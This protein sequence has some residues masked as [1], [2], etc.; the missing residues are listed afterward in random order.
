[1]YE[2]VMNELFMAPYGCG[3]AAGIAEP[4]AIWVGQLPI[5]QFPLLS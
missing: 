4:R 2:I 1:M 5:D 3:D